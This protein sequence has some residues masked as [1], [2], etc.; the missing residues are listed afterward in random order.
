[1]VS[2]VGRQLHA[3]APGILRSKI[4]LW[5]GALTTVV[6]T[7]FA[8]ALFSDISNSLWSGLLFIWQFLVMLWLALGVVGHAD[9]LAVLLGDPYG[10]LILTVS[11]IS[12][13]VIMISAIML[14]G[15]NNATL[16]RA[17]AEHRA[18]V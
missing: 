2:S 10:T 4:A 16:A 17:G 11:V 6:F 3:S 13:E 8:E 7:I 14:T 15:E 5:V 1:M 12:I 18:S 9:S